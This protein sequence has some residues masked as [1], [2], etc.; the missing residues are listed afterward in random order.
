MTKF[1]PH[2]RGNGVW[3]D[4]PRNSPKKHHGLSHTDAHRSWIAMMQR[5][6]NKRSSNYSRYG[7]LGISV[8]D[9][10]HLFTNFHVDMGDRPSG[11]SL[12]RIDN[13]KG[14][15]KENCRWETINQQARN[16]RHSKTLTI[17]GITKP[18]AE[19]AEDAGISY[20]VL[21]NR[22]ASAFC[23]EDQLLSPPGSFRT[24]I[25]KGRKF[26]PE[27]IA[28]I[29]ASRWGKRAKNI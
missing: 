18:L 7:G 21:Y 29:H 16:T 22:V 1:G 14:Y 10:W 8:C 24:E 20:H 26:S 27:H 23:N 5:C 15:Y 19:W 3:G 13:A 2:Y 12:G 17:N 9:R 11:L 6:Y 4:K 25:L 28:K